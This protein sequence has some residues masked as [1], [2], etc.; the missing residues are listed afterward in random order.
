M[1]IAQEKTLLNLESSAGNTEDN[2]QLTRNENCAKLCRQ[3]CHT[4]T[5]MIDGQDGISACRSFHATGGFHAI[6]KLISHSATRAAAIELLETLTVCDP[7]EGLSAILVMGW[8]TCKMAILLYLYLP[9]ES[10]A[11][12]LYSSE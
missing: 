12:A 7:K 4:T 6:V 11:V 5:L 1:L 10:A 3:V 8:Q 2:S 9:Y